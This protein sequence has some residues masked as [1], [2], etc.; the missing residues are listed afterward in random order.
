[1]RGI[2]RFGNF[3]S[4][5]TLN[6]LA[7]SI[8]AAS[9]LA[10]VQ[11]GNVAFDWNPATLAAADG[12]ALSDWPDAV[13]GIT[14]TTPSGQ[15][16]FKAN[17]LNGKP[18]VRFAGSQ[19]FD[20]GRPTALMNLIGTGTF[21]IMVACTN[22]VAGANAIAS[23]FGAGDASGGLWF[24]CNTTNIGLYSGTGGSIPNPLGTSDLYLLFYSARTSSFNRVLSG[25]NGTSFAPAN[26]PKTSGTLDWGIGTGR[27]DTTGNGNTYSFRGDILRILVWNSHLPMVDII[28]QTRNF[29]TYYGKP[30][31]WAG[32]NKYLL[33]DGDSITA[34]TGAS[35][36]VAY[37]YPYLT[38]AT[39]TRA[40]GTWSNTGRPSAQMTDLNNDFATQFTGLSGADA[41]GI[42]V[43]GTIMEFANQRTAGA[44]LYTDTDAYFA[45]AKTLDPTWKVVFLNSTALGGSG[46]GS[47]AGDQ[48]SLGGPN[49][50]VGNNRAAHAAHYVL[51][52]TNMDALVDLFSD[53]NVGAIGANP[54]SGTWPTTD[55]FDAT[56]PYGV[57]AQNAAHGYARIAAMTAAVVGPL[58]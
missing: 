22:L 44:S 48:T 12:A 25:A 47:A 31:P 17:A 30:L 11:S 43:V 3:A 56:H 19:Y 29:F 15:P 33:M 50:T 27:H 21:T 14:A 49:S 4:R 52:Y 24:C 6:P 13:G 1:M 42:P 28:R 53:P 34:G 51:P 20:I 7:P 46:S 16:T 2:P 35:N 39:L 41:L 36:T 38:A 40:L 5:F 57:A 55:F 58:L 54:Y 8:A 37:S 23:A 45:A 26:T 10:L 32:V 9:A 18:G